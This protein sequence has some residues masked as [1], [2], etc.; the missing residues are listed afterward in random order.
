MSNRRPNDPLE[1]KSTGRIN[2]ARLPTWRFLAGVAVD[3]V[4]Q[5]PSREMIFKPQPVSTR[6]A[7][8][9]AAESGENSQ[10]PPCRSRR[11]RDF[12]SIRETGLAGSRNPFAVVRFSFYHVKERE[13]GLSTVPRGSFHR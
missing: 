1:L 2:L 12:E 4:S 3:P 11:S 7:P 6:Y 10:K 9:L 5:C 8:Q 13:F